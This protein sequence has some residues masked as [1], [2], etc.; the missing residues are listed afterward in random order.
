M[1]F[2]TGLSVLLQHIA[3][4][5]RISVQYARQ[6]YFANEY[7]IFSSEILISYRQ[8]VPKIIPLQWTQVKM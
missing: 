5:L 1:Y 4:F 6:N 2:I 3:V 8:L 7:S